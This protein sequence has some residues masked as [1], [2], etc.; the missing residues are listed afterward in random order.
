MPRYVFRQKSGTSPRAATEL[1]VDA[2]RLGAKVL[3]Q[4]DSMLY[5]EGSEAMFR[6]MI[7]AAPDYVSAPEIALAS[8]SPSA[9]SAGRRQ[10]P[11]R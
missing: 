3:S 6:K 9:V 4:T 10:S 5:V 1:A 7:E 11:G 8:G 2:T